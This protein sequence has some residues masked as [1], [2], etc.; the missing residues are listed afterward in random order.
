MQEEIRAL[1]DRAQ[2]IANRDDIPLF[3]RDAA[4]ELC[5]TIEETYVQ[6]HIIPQYV[7]G[8]WS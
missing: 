6:A 7:P 1:Y 2:A 8:E 3:I 5:E 4:T